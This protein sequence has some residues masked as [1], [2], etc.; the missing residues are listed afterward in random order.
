MMLSCIDNKAVL[1]LCSL[2][3]PPEKDETMRL[4]FNIV[5]LQGNAINL[6]ENIFI[7][8]STVFYTAANWTNQAVLLIDG[9]SEPLITLPFSGIL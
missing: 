6:T 9:E 1:C 3:V 4:D 2:T 8:P 5:S 7:E